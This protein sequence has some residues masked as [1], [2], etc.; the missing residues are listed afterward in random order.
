M[1]ETYL[2]ERSFNN[3]SSLISLE[4]LAPAGSLAIGL[5]GLSAGAD[6]I[7]I[8]APRFGARV[9]AGVSLE[10]IA[11]L[12]N[13]AHLVGAKVYVALNT[14]LYDNELKEAERIAVSLYKAGVDALIIQDFSLLALDLPPIALHASTQCHNNNVETLHRLEVLGFEQAVLARELSID[15]TKKI[16]QSL[17][18]LHLETFIHGAL[19]VCYSGR[20]YLSQAFRG[21]SANRGE[22]AQLCRLPYNLRD[23][24]GKIIKEDKYLLSLKDLNRAS[25]LPE[26]IQ[27]G[28]TSFKIEGR[29][30]SASYVKNVTAYYRQLIDSIIDQNPLE[31]KKNSLGYH[32]YQF[33]PN[34][35]KSFSRGFTS[36]QLEKGTRLKENLIREGSSK[37]EGESLC[38]IR[39][40]EGKRITLEKKIPL[41]NGDGVCFYTKEGIMEGGRVNQVISP[42]QFIYQG[43]V[44]P[45]EG[46]I[47]YR[48]LD[49]AFEK[50]L[51]SPNIVR[52]LIPL[53][54]CFRA[55]SKG[56][57]LSFSLVE[58]P[59]ISI[60]VSKIVFLDKA[61]S[62]IPKE[63]IKETLCKLGNTPFINR[64]CIIELEDF[65]VP[66]SFIAEL[67]REAIVSLEKLL[68][69]RNH[70]KPRYRKSLK[71][72]R[73]EISFPTE[74]SYSVNISNSLAQS[75]Y[76]QLGTYSFT[77]AFELKERGGEILMTTKHCLKR[78]LGFCTLS[79]RPFPYEEPLFL[80]HHNMQI[81][82]EFDCVNC[83]ML[84]YKDQ[85]KKRV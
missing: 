40:I 11:S 66:L 29:L 46:T 14:I 34:P 18:S 39:S 17:S 7:Y 9:A 68:I 2:M 53:K 67:K 19:C 4:L 85:N 69:Q 20:C 51:D 61:K 36:Y 1:Q 22:C 75:V 79:H 59:L 63:K 13:Y 44:L 58:N 43:K 42:N 32:L 55:T 12:V 73:K 54:S 15:E 24:K 49:I 77:P 31:Y 30:K 47:L 33:R 6:A 25:I 5:A 35:F 81:R 3:T 8:G 41:N 57:F 21:R 56:L 64:I 52:R 26:L 78:Y 72:V 80:I 38:P 76:Q 45:K 37:S 10:D 48:N 28:V 71:E 84:L 62:S 70:A 82:L 83:Q 16:A 60:E 74:L 23:A 65:F 27:A 50:L